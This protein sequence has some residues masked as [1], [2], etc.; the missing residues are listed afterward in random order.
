MELKVRTHRVD[1]AD[2]CDHAITM[3]Q[4][5]IAVDC[6]SCIQLVYGC[7]A[8]FI[9]SRCTERPAPLTLGIQ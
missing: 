2:S 7:I 8:K 1:D 4:A 5:N 3:L 6:E 9:V